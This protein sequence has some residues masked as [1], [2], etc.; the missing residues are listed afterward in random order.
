[1]GNGSGGGTSA[2]ALVGL[3]GL[4]VKAQIVRDG[5]HWLL[6]E[7]TADRAWCPT[8]GVRAVWATDART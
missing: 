5:E 2:T 4:V 3:E 1:V 7:P 6:V 8:C